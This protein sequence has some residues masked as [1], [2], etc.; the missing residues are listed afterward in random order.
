MFSERASGLFFISSRVYMGYHY[1]VTTA[2]SVT[3]LFLHTNTN[4]NKQPHRGWDLGRVFDC[5]YSREGDFRIQAVFG[6][7]F[8]SCSL[9]SLLRRKRSNATHRSVRNTETE[10]ILYL[11]SGSTTRSTLFLVSG[12]SPTPTSS[13]FLGSERHKEAFFRRYPPP[14]PWIS[15]RILVF[16]LAQTRYTTRRTSQEERAHLIS[17]PPF[18]L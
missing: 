17:G 3:A 12:Y 2:S 5:I 4:I 13:P 18:L 8:F 14:L 6:F 16:L 1:Q 10:T 9:S 15:L 7:F 11:D